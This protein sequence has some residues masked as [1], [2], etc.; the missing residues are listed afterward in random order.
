VDHEVLKDAALE[1]LWVEF[2]CASYYLE[3]ADE[4]HAERMV[5]A[6]AA[7]TTAGSKTGAGSGAGAGAGAGA[8]HGMSGIKSEASVPTTSIVNRD[9]TRHRG[10][11][12]T[13]SIPVPVVGVRTAGTGG[14]PASTAATAAAV[15]AIN[16]PATAAA[17]A[18]AAATS[19]P[20]H[21]TTATAGGVAAISPSAP[22]PTTG[23]PVS[24][25]ASAPAAATGKSVHLLGLLDGKTTL[26]DIWDDEHDKGAGE[27]AS[28][29]STGSGMLSYPVKGVQY[30]SP[31]PPPRRE[32]VDI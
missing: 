24:P 5:A 14:A 1:S 4:A 22:A 10:G 13:T 30:S 23:T 18:T 25:A 27:R 19:P 32:L 28:G 11:G 26:S 12:D 2:P 9:G 8:V 31:S 21:R 7:A 3:S 20:T 6:A 29:N 16:T 17:A 15:T